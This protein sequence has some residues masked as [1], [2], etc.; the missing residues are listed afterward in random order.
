MSRWKR[1]LIVLCF[2]QSITLLGF[3]A[4]LPFIP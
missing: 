1:N 3:S 4:Y 2:A